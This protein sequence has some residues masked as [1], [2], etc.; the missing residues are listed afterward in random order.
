METRLIQEGIEAILTQHDLCQPLA[1]CKNHTNDRKDD[2]E[3]SSTARVT[4]L[5]GS[6][7]SNKMFRRLIIRQHIPRSQTGKS[8]RNHR[9]TD[10]YHIN[11]HLGFYVLI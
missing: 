1:N 2:K 7:L 4:N 8:D 9:H 11:L 5:P 10:G 3:E 6:L